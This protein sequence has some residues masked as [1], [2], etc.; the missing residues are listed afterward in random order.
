[1]KKAKT[2]PVKVKNGY[3][4]P[5]TGSLRLHQAKKVKGK[6]PPISRSKKLALNG[7]KSKTY[8]LKLKGATKRALAAGK[9]VK[10]KALV[11][12][13]NSSGQRRTLTKSLTLK[14]KKGK[15]PRR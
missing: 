5:V 1:M 14:V 2:A 7:G 11:E 8:K 15:K 6:R 13:A 12:V 4:F 9:K 3:S 10:V